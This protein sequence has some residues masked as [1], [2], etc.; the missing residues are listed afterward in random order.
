MTGAALRHRVAI[1]TGLAAIGCVVSF[2]VVMTAWKA[3]APSS[4]APPPAVDFV[5]FYALGYAAVHADARNALVSQDAWRTLLRSLAPGRSNYPRLYGPSVALLF[6]PLGLLPLYPAYLIWCAFYIVVFAVCLAVWVNRDARDLRQFHFWIAAAAATFPPLVYA[7][8]QGHLS[9]VGVVALLVL[10]R[11]LSS[12]SAVLAG[13]GLGLLAFKPT[14]LVPAAAIMLLAGELR[15]VLTGLA[16]AVASLLIPVPLFGMSASAA[17]VSTIVGLAASPERVAA[18]PMLMSSL[19]TFWVMLV[20]EEMGGVL[21]AG[22]A[23]AVLALAVIAWR[24]I[25]NPLARV[26]MLALSTVLVAPHVYVYDLVVLIP[27]GLAWSRWALEAEQRWRGPL[28]GFSALVFASPLLAP[29]ALHT[30]VQLITL[31]H[32]GWFLILWRNWARRQA[33]R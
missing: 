9:I 30:G 1:W 10:T 4:A 11:G 6:A 24:R 17:Y 12:R 28:Y 13:V 31:I 15:I 20:G 21:Y 8:T 22:N 5:Q 19:R 25:S 26:G 18:D 16:V 32:L 23:A 29:V 7:L 2:T 14:L 33:L 3:Q 27:T